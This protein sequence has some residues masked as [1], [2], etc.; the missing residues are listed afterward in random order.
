MVF[1]VFVSVQCGK[2]IFILDPNEEHFPSERVFNAPDSPTL[3]QM[4]L[5]TFG[6]QDTECL[7]KK[8]QGP[9]LGGEGEG[10]PFLKQYAKQ[11][12]SIFQRKLEGKIFLHKCIEDV[13]R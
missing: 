3:H 13:C 1:M 6:D 8:Q 9:E 5:K 10:K 2:L 11:A 7:E 4:T 12:S